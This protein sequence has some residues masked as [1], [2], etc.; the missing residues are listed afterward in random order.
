MESKPAYTDFSP[1]IE[2]IRQAQNRVFQRINSELVNLYWDIGKYISQ[3]VNAGKWGDGVVKQLAEHIRQEY[4]KLKGFTKRG[5]YR[6]KQFYET[7]N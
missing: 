5:L 6:M 4:P 7:Y 1:V 3:K 2:R